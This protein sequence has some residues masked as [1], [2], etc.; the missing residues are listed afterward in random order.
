MCDH[1]DA[2]QLA[3]RA[4]RDP[5][6]HASPKNLHWGNVRLARPNTRLSGEPTTESTDLEWSG[7][8]NRTEVIMLV[9]SRKV[10]EAIVIDGGI[11]IRVAEVH[12]GRVRL[13]I[14]APRET[15]VDRAEV[16]DRV[17]AAGFQSVADPRLIPD[18][19]V[20]LRRPKCAAAVL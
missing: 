8:V 18:T 3:L 1:V 13:A 16:H 9:L 5:N 4:T 2:R 7:R 15:R 10:G 20:T 11:L 12:G 19:P 17:A 6:C 14:E